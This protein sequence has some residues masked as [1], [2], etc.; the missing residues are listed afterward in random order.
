MKNYRRELLMFQGNIEY[1]LEILEELDL[2][3][4]SIIEV[5]KEIIAR[6][7]KILEE[8]FVSS[9]KFKELIWEGAAISDKLSEHA[10][11]I[12]AILLGII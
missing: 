9:A 8:E 7:E 6:C 1:R 5:H 10:P 11:N 2:E 4:K 3:N 12:L